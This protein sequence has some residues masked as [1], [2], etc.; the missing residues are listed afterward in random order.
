[1][2]AS[3]REGRTSLPLTINGA[4]P[5]EIITLVVNVQRDADKGSAVVQYAIG[6]AASK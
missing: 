2:P 4:R 3:G 6:I 1:M 5:F